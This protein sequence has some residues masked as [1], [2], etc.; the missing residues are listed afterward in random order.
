MLKLPDCGE[1][2]TQTSNGTSRRLVQGVSGQARSDTSLRERSSYRN[3]W[4]SKLELVSFMVAAH[5][6]GILRISDK[7]K[8]AKTLEQEFKNFQLKYTE[9]GNATFSAREGLHDD[10]VLSLAIAVWYSRRNEGRTVTAH[11]T[12]GH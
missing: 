1:P 3:F 8:H 10:L 9:K 6:Q 4:V 7:L 5:H 12:M 11:E 2:A